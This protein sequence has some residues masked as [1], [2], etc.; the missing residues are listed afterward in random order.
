MGG[1]PRPRPRSQ[2]GGTAEHSGGEEREGGGGGRAPGGGPPRNRFRRRMPR[3]PGKPRNQSQSEQQDSKPEESNVEPI[4][5]D[6]SQ[7]V[8]NTTTESTA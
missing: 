7:A 1:G 3:Q 6:E 8:Q 5:Q 2:D 4:K